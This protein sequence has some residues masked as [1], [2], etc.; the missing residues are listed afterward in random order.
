MFMNTIPKGEIEEWNGFFP[1]SNKSCLNLK[2]P[3]EREEKK[4]KEAGTPQTR[5]LMFYIVSRKS[6]M[7]ISIIKLS[8]DIIAYLTTFNWIFE[9]R[10]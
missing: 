8:Y 5:Y 3:K 6:I 2:L 9:S 10:I 1:Q 7:T 4:R